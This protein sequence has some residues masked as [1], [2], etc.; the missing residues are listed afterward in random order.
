MKIIVSCSP[1]IQLHLF[2]FLLRVRCEYQ[3]HSQ[4][5]TVNMKLPLPNLALHKDWKQWEKAS[6]ALSEGHKI[7]YQHL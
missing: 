4:V 5:C 7:A 2:V 6:L 3:Y 1:N